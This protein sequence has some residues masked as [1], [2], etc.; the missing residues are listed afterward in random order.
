M[1]SVSFIA[2]SV[3]PPVCA[4]HAA[5]HSGCAAMGNLPEISLPAA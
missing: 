4:G 3:P 1:L 2:V 5:N